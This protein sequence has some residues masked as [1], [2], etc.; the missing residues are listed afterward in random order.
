MEFKTPK[1]LIDDQS[2]KVRVSELA[3]DITRDY[4]GRN[5][6]VIAV[7]KGSFLFLAD[8]VRQIDLHCYV[9]FLEVQSYDGGL[10]S[11]GVV[12][13]TKDL[14]YP[15]AGMDILIVEDIIETGLTLDYLKR[16]LKTRNPKSVKICVLLNKEE[17]RKVDIA[18]DYS[19]FKIDDKFVVGYGLDY[20]GYYRNLKYVGYFEDII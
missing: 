12:K 18:V 4:A 11:R 16:N 17:K 15:I 9:E 6:V 20:M 2:L 14:T 1:I 19:G 8:L 13:M 3:R 10:K 5:I 7:L